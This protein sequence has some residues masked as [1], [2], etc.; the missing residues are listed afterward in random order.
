MW[1]KNT[2]I[3]LSVAFLD[4]RGVVL[5]IADMKPQTEEPHCANGDAKF[6]LEMNLG[7]FATRKIGPGIR[8]GGIERAPAPR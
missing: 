5:N 4:A 7:W 6:A 8:I 1:M 2:F 3:P